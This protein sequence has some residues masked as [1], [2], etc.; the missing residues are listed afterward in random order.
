MRFIVVG[1]G[2][3]G[4]SRIVEERELAGPPAAGLKAD[5]LWSTSQ[6]PPEIPVARHAID[7]SWLNAGL[8]AGA[9]RWLIVSFAAGHKAEMHHTS[10][11][12]YDIV[13]AGETTLGTEEGEVVM[14]PGDCAMIPGSMH[15]WTAGPEGFTMA[16]MLL[17]LADDA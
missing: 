12:D 17:G 10:T 2:P 3:E 16:S 14:R 7:A 9:S 6:L 4:K 5:M 13:L 15:S 1:V 8:A 11:L